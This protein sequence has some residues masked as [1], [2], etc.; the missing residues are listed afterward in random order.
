MLECLCVG[1]VESRIFGVR[2]VFGMDT[3]HIFSQGV[4]TVVPLTEGVCLVSW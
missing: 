1:C 2:G 3:C 4:L